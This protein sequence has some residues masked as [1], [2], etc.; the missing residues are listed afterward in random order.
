MVFTLTNQISLSKVRHSSAWSERHISS[1]RGSCPR[2][3]MGRFWLSY[4][5]PNIGGCQLYMS[6]VHDIDVYKLYKCVIDLSV[7]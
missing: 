3:D 2:L 4:K 7:L 5:S 1:G 6:I